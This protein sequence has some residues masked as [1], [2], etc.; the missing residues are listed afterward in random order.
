MVRRTSVVVAHRINTIRNCDAIAVL[1]KGRVVERGRMRRCS[2]R[3]NP[4][5]TF[6]LS[7]F[8]NLITERFLF[9]FGTAADECHNYISMKVKVSKPAKD[10]LEI[11][12]TLNVTR[13]AMRG[14]CEKFEESLLASSYRWWEKK[15]LLGRSHL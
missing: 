7:D 12:V 1:D 6:H 10:A 3:G 9:A 11:T 2:R 5:L 4:G 15:G 13:E 14:D 8:N